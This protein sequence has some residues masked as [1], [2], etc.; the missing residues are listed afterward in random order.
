MS[1]SE[2]DY[3]L[4]G[5]IPRKRISRTKRKI[6]LLLTGLIVIAAT[7]FV[8]KKFFENKEMEKYLSNDSNKKEIKIEDFQ[9][10]N[11]NNTNGPITI[12]KELNDGTKINLFTKILDNPDNKLEN[13]FYDNETVEALPLTIE[14]E[15]KYLCEQSF[16]LTEEGSNGYDITCP[17]YYSIKIDKAFYGRYAGDTERCSV[18]YKGDQVNKNNLSV[19]KNCGKSV[20]DIA[21]NMCEG[22]STCHIASKKEFPDTCN[23]IGKYLHLEYHCA[24]IDK[25]QFKVPR[26]AIVMYANDVKVNSLYENSI[27]EFYQYAKIHG[28]SFIFSSKR[29]D[30]GRDLFYMKLHVITEAL[31]EGLKNNEYDWIFWVDGDTILGNPNIKLE[32]FLPMD[33][34]IHFMA[35]RDGHG[36]NAGV[37]FIRVNSWSL[38][39]M[40]RSISYQYYNRKVKVGFADQTSMNNVLVTDKEDKH[41]VIVPQRWFNIYSYLKKPGDFIIHLAGRPKKDELS[42]EIH[43]EIYA[44]DDWIKAKTNKQ[45][46]KEVIDYYNKPRSEQESTFY[47]DD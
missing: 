47:Y 21:K 4:L 6:V 3:V 13:F 15:S 12:N 10:V 45:L 11:A 27:S 24:K 32:T 46:R 31:I 37:F 26:I 40:M 19:N 2:A 28:Y 29:Y 35:A 38:N 42:K 18:D 43:N 9:Y 23:G 16:G 36:L 33:N 25:N 7:I 44:N 5:N 30:T 41:Y 17:M 20:S 14:K 39:F 22:K 34:D 1:S 8:S